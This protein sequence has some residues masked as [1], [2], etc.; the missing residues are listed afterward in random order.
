VEVF[1][2]LDPT[3]AMGKEPVLTIG[4][5][6]GIHRGH[7]ALVARIQQRARERDG[8]GVVLTFDPH[9][10]RVI[11]PG[12]A[13][14]LLTTTEE[15]LS[16]LEESGLDNLVI[17]PF[18]RELSQMEAE[19]FVQDVL[20]GRLGVRLLVLG[21]DHAFGRGRR[22]RPELLKEMAPRLGFELEL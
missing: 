7:Q 16:I 6:D 4:S 2:G 9:P 11:V 14:P 17:V 15:K 13:P 22:G 1:L 3:P 10:Q 12:T 8:T 18:N 19:D 20:L 21:Y 5:F